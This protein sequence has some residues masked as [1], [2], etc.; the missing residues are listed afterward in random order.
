MN[1][2]N[3]RQEYLTAVLAWKAKYAKLTLDIRQ[4]KFSFRKAQQA[5][6]AAQTIENFGAVVGTRTAKRQLSK[7]ATEMLEDRA[8]GKVRAQE[9]YLQSRETVN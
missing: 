6:S 1:D 5:Y 7:M 2:F 8:T 3:T 9:L 4:A